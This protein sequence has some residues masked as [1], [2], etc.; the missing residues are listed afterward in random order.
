MTYFS[1]G[2][3]GNTPKVDLRTPTEVAA[4]K[5]RSASPEYVLSF[6]GQEP[7]FNGESGLGF[8]I[9]NGLTLIEFPEEGSVKQIF[10]ECYEVMWNNYQIGKNYGLKTHATVAVDLH[11]KGFT[12]TDRGADNIATV[13]MIAK[14]SIKIND[15]QIPFEAQAGLLIATNNKL[16]TYLG[17][18]NK[19]FAN[20]NVPLHFLRVTDNH[21]IIPTTREGCI[22]ITKR[23][24]AQHLRNL[25]IE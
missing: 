5:L 15:K 25:K 4:R 19:F 17:N 22:D 13:T 2:E 21:G 1:K 6:I 20:T 14:N 9:F 12:F 7:D 3:T 16:L 23:L 24:L 8:T 18:I 11:P 10:R